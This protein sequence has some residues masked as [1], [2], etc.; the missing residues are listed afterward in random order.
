L[1]LAAASLFGGELT[2]ATAPANAGTVGVTGHIQGAGSIVSVEGGPYSCNR[3][4][5][6]DD[7]NT[8][9]CDR[10]S[11]GAVFEACV[12]LE[13]RPATT[14]AGNW[15]FDRWEGCNTT[16]VVNGN[17]QCAVHSGAFTLDEKSPK[18]VF[19]DFV[20]PTITNVTPTQSASSDRQFSFTFGS[21]DSSSSSTCAMDSRRRP[22][23]EEVPLTMDHD[24]RGGHG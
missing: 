5:N 19:D 14:P 13:V 16:R 23:P 15:R 1:T 21:N 11:F 20:S 22:V 8:V 2:L 3:D 24:P 7:R 6:Q 17:V 4:G 12:W 10:I 9:T 18:A